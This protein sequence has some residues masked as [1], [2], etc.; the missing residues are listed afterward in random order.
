M[1]RLI[2]Q[3]KQMPRTASDVFK[4]LQP[5]MIDNIY[6]LTAIH[7]NSKAKSKGRRFTI[8]PQKFTLHLD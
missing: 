1:K 7:I 4:T 6:T 3:Q 5:S 2:K 8:W